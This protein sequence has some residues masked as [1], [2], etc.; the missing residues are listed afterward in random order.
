MRE[1]IG[2]SPVSCITKVA[3]ILLKENLKKLRIMSQYWSHEYN[4]RDW[5]SN[6][7]LVTDYGKLSCGLQKDVT[8]KE[9]NNPLTCKV[10]QIRQLI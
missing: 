8:I 4:K 9:S 2:K 5:S 7:S 10:W 3:R 1:H 6:S